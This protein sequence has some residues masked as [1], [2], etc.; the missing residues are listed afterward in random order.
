M[1]N[2][3]IYIFIIIAVTTYNCSNTNSSE[4]VSEIET[5]KPSQEELNE[6]LKLAENNCFSCHSPNASME[7]RLAP[8]MIAVKKHYIDENISFEDFKTEFMSFLDSPSEEKTKMPGAVRR[9]DL[10][11]KMNFKS[12]DISK[13]AVYLYY[14]EIEKPEWFEKHHQEEKGK[15][16]NTIDRELSFLQK[17]RKIAINTKKVLG[18]N[19]IK[20][21]NSKGTEV[22]LSF[23]STRAIPIT[24]SMSIALNA[25]IKRVSDK[26]RNHKN[27][28]NQTELAYINKAK[29]SLEK[30]KE[31]KP[32]LIELENKKVGYYPILTNQ[33]CLQCHGQK[34]SDISINTLSKIKKLYP[35]D[36]AIGYKV[37]ELRGIWV[38]E[39]DKE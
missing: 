33:M 3:T 13:I 8:P 22:A 34:E 15:Y 6:G 26:N 37:N 20:A 1:K 10:M 35:K 16:K 31:P 39:M 9:F 32:Q 5:E 21:I 2:Y 19:L 36:L 24:D 29:L 18:K 30:G 14:S 28:A 27:N 11:P 23:C 25:K 17:G 38:V 12:E 4:K 7:N